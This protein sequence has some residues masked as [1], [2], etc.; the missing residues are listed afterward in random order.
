MLREE[1][2]TVS[3]SSETSFSESS[4]PEKNLPCVREGSIGGV[5]REDVRLER[6]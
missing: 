4:L 1:T 6:V 2:E 5:G 3:V